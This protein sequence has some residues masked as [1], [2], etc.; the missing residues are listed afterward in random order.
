MCTEQTHLDLKLDA[1]RWAAEVVLIGEIDIGDGCVIVLANCRACQ[2][3]LA[4]ERHR[5]GAR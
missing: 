5:A 3:T 4:V 2:S 1:A